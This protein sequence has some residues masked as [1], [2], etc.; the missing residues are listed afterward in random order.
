MPTSWF[1]PENTE[2]YSEWGYL[3]LE[4]YGTLNYPPRGDDFQPNPTVDLALD[5]FKQKRDSHE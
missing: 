2:P 5:R 1:P 4:G 3:G